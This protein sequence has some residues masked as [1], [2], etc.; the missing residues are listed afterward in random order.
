MR[1][2]PR[3]WLETE[4]YWSHTYRPAVPIVRQRVLGTFPVDGT[5]SLTYVIP[6]ITLTVYVSTTW[7]PQSTEK[8]MLKSCDIVGFRAPSAVPLGLGQ[9]VSCAITQGAL[10]Q[11]SN[12]GTIAGVGLA[13]K[14]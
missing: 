7:L 5:E 11:S 1:N 2:S 13:S 10:F 3:I 9:Y 4:S 6:I 8:T 12:R 14:D